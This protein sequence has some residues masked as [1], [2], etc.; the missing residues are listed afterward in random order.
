M[1]AEIDIDL[2]FP[3]TLDPR[4][5]EQFEK[6][7]RRDKEFRRRIELE[8]QARRRRLRNPYAEIEAVTKRGHW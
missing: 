1:A 2:V 4:L 8:R 6:A 5:D 7:E 3:S